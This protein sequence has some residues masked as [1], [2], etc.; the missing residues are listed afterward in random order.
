MKIMK[1]FRRQVISLKLRHFVAGPTFR[2]KV[3]SVDRPQSHKGDLFQQFTNT[4]L[5]AIGVPLSIQGGP[6]GKTVRAT[7]PLRIYLF[8]SR[9]A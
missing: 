8:S 5:L 7:I 6:K 3:A 1:L 2:R 4:V 9:K